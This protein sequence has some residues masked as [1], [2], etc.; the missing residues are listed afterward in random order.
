MHDGRNVKLL[1]HIAMALPESVLRLFQLLPFPLPFTDSHFLMPDPTNQILAISSGVD[2]LSME[3]SVANLLN[4][5]Q[6]NSA[7]QCERHSVLRRQ[8]NT[9]CLGSL[10]IQDFT[11]ATTL[12]EMQIVEHTETVLQMQDNWYLVYSPVA[13]TG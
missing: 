13:F 10:Y 12:C 8:I 3:M 7:Y 5:H 4:C 6:I 2:R 1:L 11:G 9:T